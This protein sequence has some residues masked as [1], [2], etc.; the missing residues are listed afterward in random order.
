MFVLVNN[1]AAAQVGELRLQRGVQ[2]PLVLLQGCLVC[3]EEQEL[4]VALAGAG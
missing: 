1:P 4:P 3:R 2:P